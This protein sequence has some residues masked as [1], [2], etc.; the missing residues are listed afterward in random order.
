MPLITAT[1]LRDARQALFGWREQGGSVALVPTMGALHK[2]HTAL[3]EQA[4]KMAKHTVVSIFVNPLQ[5]APGEDLDLYPRTFEADLEMLADAGVDLLYA[6][7]AAEMYPPGFAAAIDPGPL[8]VML[9]G[10]F[11]PGHF[12]GVATVVVKLLLQIMPDA[13]LFGEKDYQQLLVVQ[14]VVR[15]LDMPMHIIGVPTVRDAD[16]LA[17]S[18]RNAY[19][20]AQERQQAAALPRTLSEV[21]QKIAAG[22]D[23]EKT[24]H[25][26]RQQLAEAGFSLQYLELADAATLN[27]VRSL[28]APARLL[29][30]ARIGSTRLIDNIAV[31]PLV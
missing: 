3:V 12:V 26:G 15:E 11:R 29:A 24:L 5:F 9:E 17:L 27:P 21:A 20:T 19:L 14:R 8:G 30:A 25:L 31:G 7:G 16:G 28:E 22:E 10:A 13:A 23:V 18:S 4:R 1:R 2:G 6:P